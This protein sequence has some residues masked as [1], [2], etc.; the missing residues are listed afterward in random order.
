[1]FS[2]IVNYLSHLKVKNMLKLHDYYWYFFK[3]LRYMMK[4]YVCINIS[5]ICYR[6]H[7]IWASFYAD[8]K[9]AYIEL[10]SFNVKHIGEE[11]LATV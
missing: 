10:L 1:M 2:L 4:H 11:L 8:F 3:L 5:L 6:R 7:Q 9:A